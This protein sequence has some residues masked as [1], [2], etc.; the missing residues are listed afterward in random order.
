MK[1]GLLRGGYGNSLKFALIAFSC[2][3]LS[4]FSG[5]SSGDEHEQD[6]S[7]APLTVP[8]ATCGE[9]D[10]PETALQGQVP[11]AM[12][13][14]GFKGFNCNLQLLGQSR[15]DGANW[16]TTE[17]RDEQHHVC[18]YHG[19][20][21][22]TV[23][24][25]HLGVPVVDITDPRDP[26]PTGYLTTTSML[27][28]WESLK[29][30][31]RRQL[32]GADNAHNGGFGA[33][34]PEVDIYDISGDCRTPQLLATVAVGKA[35][36]ST[37]LPH[38]VIGHEGSWAPDGLTYYGGDLVYAY[39]VPGS[40]ATAS[41]Q[42]YAVDTADPTHP[43]LITAWT[44][45]IAGSNVHGMS[46]SDDGNRGYFVS[47]GGLSGSPGD[48]TN[49]AVPANNGLV[50]FDLS[51]IQA[52]VPNPQVRLV[53]KLL[54]KDGSVAQHTIPVRIDG[55]PYVI[56]VDEGGSGGLSS[57]AQEQA[58]C[59]AGLTPFPLARIIDIRDE[60]KPKIVSRLALEVHNPANC[61]KVLPDLVGLSTFTY[62]SHYCSVDNKHRATTLACGYFNS[63]I[64]V[65]DIRNPHHPK[66]IAYYN[67]AGETTLSPG[68]N[69][70]NIFSSNFVSGGPDWCS[71]QVHLRISE[72]HGRQ[73]TLWT[74]CQD[75]G[76]L[77]LKFENGVWP[78]ED[79]STPPGQQN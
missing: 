32:L 77:M 55:H 68:S 57:P 16:Q 52:R 45:G 73:G 4:F 69:H 70:N 79:S 63:G 25:S 44:T 71:A 1:P 7:P 18:A 48:L 60:T 30:N 54:W 34:G 50:I 62:G 38:P 67:P 66:E 15:G 2:G 53:S 40:T 78:F 23:N 65:F 76:L 29:V 24:R 46:I 21:F 20:S 37:G 58:A 3:A 8:K 27:D 12:R 19:T 59:A 56:F 9:N 13:A 72:D 49:P 61:S 39:T 33:G 36:G 14:A 51:Q 41:G 74:T 17:F 64:R 26:T 35:D 75:N 11:A 42:Y 22:S 28:P 47:I 31:E 5:W 10:H 6:D 43:A